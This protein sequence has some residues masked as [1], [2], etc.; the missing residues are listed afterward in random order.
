MNTTLD[1]LEAVKQKLKK[2]DEE[3]SDYR[4]AKELEISRAAVS[5]YKN[6]GDTL[7]EETAMKVASILEIEPIVVLAAIHAEKAK[8][9]EIKAAWRGLVERLGSVAAMCLIA[10]GINAF[11]PAPALASETINTTDDLYIMRNKRRRR[12]APQKAKIDLS[13]LVQNL[14]GFA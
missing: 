5:K 11:Q 9:A 13:F 6:K 10:T 12:K 8:T 3:V 7:S 14:V 2:G 4:L 1:Y